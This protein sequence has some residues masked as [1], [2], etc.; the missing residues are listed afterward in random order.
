MRYKDFKIVEAEEDPYGRFNA[1]INMDSFYK[2]ME[3]LKNTTDPKQAPSDLEGIDA[4]VRLGYMG[5][6]SE[7][8]LTRL[9]TSLPTQTGFGGRYNSSDDSLILKWDIVF[10]PRDSNSLPGTSTA[11]HELRHRAFQIM[12]VDPRFKSLLPAELTTGKWKDGWGRNIDWK[13]YS[14]TAEQEPFKGQGILVVPEHAMIYAVQHRNIETHQKAEWINNSVLGNR[15]AEYWRDLY[16]RV[17]DACK[18]FFQKH[19]DARAI[20]AVYPARGSRDDTRDI[21][22]LSPQ[23]KAYYSS[24]S[25]LSPKEADNFLF[26]GL[27]VMATASDGAGYSFVE[28]LVEIWNKGHLRDVD[29]WLKKHRQRLLALN[30]GFQ[31]AIDAIEKTRPYWNLLD[32]RNFTDAQVRTI[33][34]APRK[35]TAPVVPTKPVAVEPANKPPTTIV[36]PRG[37][38]IGFIQFAKQN[39]YGNIT[40]WEYIL[41]SS[42]AQ[43]LQAA[44][45]HTIVD[46]A[47]AGLYVDRSTKEFI[48]LLPGVWDI[49]ESAGARKVLAETY[50]GKVFLVN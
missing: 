24:W 43:R 48:D 14:I 11:A 46:A 25:F 6:V 2:N 8:V 21:V 30:T 32:I 49:V 33:V 41:S 4:V 44:L 38:K 19:F 29:G 37:N 26:A 27:F 36:A 50:L 12:S 17:N 9:G 40:L 39:K 1:S 20:P 28:D 35:P 13:K 42:N 10:E 3:L 15:G 47:M 7:G 34:A 22:N 45:N 5:S 31:P 23:M 18:T 16:Q